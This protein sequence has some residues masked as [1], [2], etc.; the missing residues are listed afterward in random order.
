[1]NGQRRRGNERCLRRWLVRRQWEGEVKKKKILHL[2]SAQFCS[3]IR[4]NCKRSPQEERELE[5]IYDV[6]YAFWYVE[7][8]DSLHDLGI[9]WNLRCQLSLE[10]LKLKHKTASLRRW[11]QEKCTS[12][13]IERAPLTEH[14]N[15]SSITKLSLPLCGSEATCLATIWIRIMLN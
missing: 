13:S 5:W 9:L 15:H 11:R 6:S 10:R 7:S 14:F 2:S 3:L 8:D 4:L 1:M 12:S